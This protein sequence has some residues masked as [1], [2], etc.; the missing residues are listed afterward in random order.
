MICSAPKNVFRTLV[1]AALAAGTVLTAYPQQADSPAASDAVQQP[2]GKDRQSVRSGSL[3]I[4]ATDKTNPATVKEESLPVIALDASNIREMPRSEKQPIRNGKRDLALTSPVPDDSL[5]ARLTDDGD[6]VRI[7][8]PAFGTQGFR[9]IRLDAF[10]VSPDGSVLAIAERTGISTGPNGTRIVLLNTH[11]WDTLRIF[12]TDLSL[13]K[14][15]FVPGIDA[16]AA[17]AFPQSDLKQQLKLVAFDL[18]RPDCAPF[19]ELPLPPPGKEPLVAEKVALLANGGA[20]FCSGY[21]GTKAIVAELQPNAE[22]ESLRVKEFSARA[23]ATAMAVTPDGSR[24]ALASRKNIEYFS[25]TDKDGQLSLSSTFTTLD[26]GWYP[27]DLKFLGGA[28]TDFIVCPSF[29]EDSPPV[30]VR[31]STKD[32][33]D[34]RSA[35]FAVPCKD[36]KRIGVAFK[37]KGRIDVVNPATIEVEDSVI[38]DQMRPATN[39]SPVFVHYLDPIH[40]F[41]VIDSVG[42]AYAVGRNEGDKR[43]SKRIIWNG[44]GKR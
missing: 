4:S 44:A 5:A 40:A 30:V 1:L 38:L 9:G 11:T 39:G 31:S 19:F 25:V 29:D 14:L 27:V 36:G 13:K 8:R 18:K 42:N 28:Q 32:S 23:P 35:G 37:V 17:V 26:L 22:G 33:L 20:L 34:G 12:T 7:W 2:G 3:A 41:F 21:N 43:W 10:A 6:T 24:V 15:A 16:L